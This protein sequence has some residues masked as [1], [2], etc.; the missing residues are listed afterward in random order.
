MSTHKLLEELNVP[1]PFDRAIAHVE[2]STKTNDL[3]SGMDIS[4]SAFFGHEQVSFG[5]DD[6][7]VL[8]A[9]CLITQA[10]IVARHY[11]CTSQLLDESA[12]KRVAGLE[13]EQVQS[14]SHEATT[15][16]SFDSGAGGEAAA[17]RL[18]ALAKL[19]FDRGRS[20]KK[21][22][23][24]SKNST[25]HQEQVEIGLDHIRINENTDNSPLSGKLVNLPNCWRITPIDNSKPYALLV[26]LRVRRNWMPLS[27]PLLEKGQPGF[28]D[29]LAKLWNGGSLSD[30]F[31]RQ[32]FT[33]LLEHLV[34]RGLQSADENTYATLAAQALVAAP[35]L[36]PLDS[37][38]LNAPLS[39]R[40][41]ILP[42]DILFQALTYPPRQIAHLLSVEGVERS[43][44]EHLVKQAESLERDAVI[45]E[46]ERTKITS[47]RDS[48]GFARKIAKWLRKI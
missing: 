5:L 1:E 48:V 46:G 11:N 14:E 34:K 7:G 30:E 29:T 45:I 27:E 15:S 38:V 39:P 42:S 21:K 41:I 43:E 3:T 9:D 16:S 23:I 44:V 24:H 8:D 6:G 36:D 37:V 25:R 10:H 18:S 26:E 28:R 35:S 4:V 22:T 13:M 12:T 33:L 19:K 40:K 32:A 31:H 17:G 20:A 47:R 2:I